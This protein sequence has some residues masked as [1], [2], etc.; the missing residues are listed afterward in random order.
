MIIYILT[1]IDSYNKDLV[2][3]NINNIY[4]KLIKDYKMNK[5]FSYY[6]TI[7][8][9]NN[10]IGNYTISIE[11][12]Y[13]VDKIKKSLLYFFLFLL[14]ALLLQVFNLIIAEILICLSFS[15]VISS[16]SNIIKLGINK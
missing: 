3:L 7:W 10:L 9:G 2:T 8:N 5:D 6:L 4:K 13:V 14:F 12:I 16:I 1:E 11:N 15:Y